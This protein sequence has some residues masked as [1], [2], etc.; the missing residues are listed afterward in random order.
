MMDHRNRVIENCNEMTP[1]TTMQVNLLYVMEMDTHCTLLN[2][3]DE[4]SIRKKNFGNIKLYSIRTIGRYIFVF[5]IF[6]L[7]LHITDLK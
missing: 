4:T 7:H 6:L 2:D 5:L 3:G 1:K